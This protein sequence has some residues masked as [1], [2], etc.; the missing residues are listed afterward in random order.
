MTKIDRWLVRAAL[1]ALT[2]LIF[3]ATFEVL[4]LGEHAKSSTA[5][6]TATINDTDTMVRFISR[7]CLARDAAG[8]LQAPGTL[9][10]VD[11]LA[12]SVH[13]LAVTTQL[14]V[15]NSTQLV[16]AT[17]GTLTQGA[18]DLHRTADALNQQLQAIGPLLQSLKT[19]SDQIPPTM[20]KL[21]ASLDPV[22]QLVRDA[23]TTV[24]NINA[25]VEDPSNA[26]LQKALALNATQLALIEGDFYARLHPL[27]NP[28]PCTTRSCKVKAS[29]GKVSATFPLLEAV[30]DMQR[31]WAGPNQNVKVALSPSTPQPAR[32][33]KPK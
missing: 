32:N 21:Q 7:P 2:S 14:Q 28:D 30:Y 11:K 24:K 27:L 29:F 4:T 20:Q 16:Q 1:V 6:L 13:D 8:K 9:C 23:D 10:N 26:E 12:N 19:S 5:A 15:H 22:P 25:R 17:T 31:I 18:A 33:V 3:V